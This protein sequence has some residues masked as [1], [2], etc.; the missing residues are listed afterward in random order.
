MKSIS[1]HN[2]PLQMK[3]KSI[4]KASS[5]PKPFS[6]TLLEKDPKTVGQ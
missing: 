3:I 5:K 1:S 4:N 2:D 6:M